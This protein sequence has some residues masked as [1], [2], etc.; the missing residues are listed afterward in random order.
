MQSLFRK[1]ESL[2]FPG[3]R[4]RALSL[5]QGP[6]FLLAVGWYSLAAKIGTLPSPAGLFH[7]IGTVWSR[8]SSTPA[9]PSFRSPRNSKGVSMISDH[10]AHSHQRTEAIHYRLE[11][12][13]TRHQLAE[14]LAWCHKTLVPGSWSHHRHGENLL[15]EGAVVARLTRL[16]G[17]YRP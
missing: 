6:I 2:T 10:T 8:A 16:P 11:V 3:R 9:T 12:W 7:R 14:M 15:G 17:S 13:V 1:I 5:D 4:G